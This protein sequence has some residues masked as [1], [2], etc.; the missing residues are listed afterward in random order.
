[1][2]GEAESKFDVADQI[3]ASKRWM[4]PRREAPKTAASAR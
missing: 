2:H 3:V 4:T 1:M